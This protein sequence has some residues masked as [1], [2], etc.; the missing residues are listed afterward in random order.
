MQDFWQWLA[1]ASG[2]IVLALLAGAG[3]SALLELLW[4]PRRDR[5]RAAK[6]LL[7]ELAVN[8]ELLLLH[9]HAR[10]T[11]PGQIPADLRMSTM[12][13]NAVAPM[14]SELPAKLVR[15]LVVLYNRYDSLNR[16]NVLF[17]EALRDKRSEDRGTQITAG[18]MATATLN[19]FNT[20]VDATIN[21]GKELLKELM[22]VAGWKETSEERAQIVDYA[23][24]TAKHMAGRQDQ[25]AKL[26]QRADDSRGQ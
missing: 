25:L 20:G 6:L 21:Q 19:A 5:R 13:W 22:P 9:A 11:S 26:N 8:T 24:I 17:A 10:T 12:A 16:Q 4:K 2:T 3:G 7:A 1:S 15:K 14:V 23:Q 18:M